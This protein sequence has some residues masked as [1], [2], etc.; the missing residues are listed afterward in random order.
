[1]M[2]IQTNF[3]PHQLDELG[4]REKTAVVVDVLRASTTIITALHNGARE[5]IP[6]ASVESAAKITGSLVGEVQIRGGERGG[7]MI[8]GFSLG[9]S[10][11]EYGEDRVK[12]KSIIYSTSNG[13]PLIVRSRFA[14][15]TLVCSFVNIG[16]VA[17][18]LKQN[19]SEIEI[20]CAGNGGRFAIEDAVCAG[21]LVN[22]LEDDS[23]ESVSLCDASQAASALYK[24]HS[25]NLLRM[26]RQSEGGKILESLGYAEDVKYCA[27]IDT[28]PVLPLL[29]GNMLRLWKE[30]ERQEPVGASQ[31]V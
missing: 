20:L 23:P 22:L 2:Q 4:L 30:S 15:H 24:T 29:C 16:A 17:A 25:R 27:G 3:A 7:K 31:S 13:S 14:R 28:L 5:V 1:M 8:E 10:P 19:G 6:T 21:F 12:D 18:F 9:N 11:L 26:L